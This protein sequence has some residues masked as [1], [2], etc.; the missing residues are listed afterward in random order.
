MRTTKEVVDDMIYCALGAKEESD[1][2]NYGDE[3]SWLRHLYTA[4]S[5]YQNDEHDLKEKFEEDIK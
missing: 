1:Q 2:S 4:C 3:K 5:E